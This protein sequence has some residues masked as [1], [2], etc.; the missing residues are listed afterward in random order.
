MVMPPSHNSCRAAILS[1]AETCGKETL[2][3]LHGFCAFVLFNASSL[4]FHPH[5]LTCVHV[6]CAFGLF[7][8]SGVQSRLVSSCHV[9]VPDYSQ[10]DG[11]SRSLLPASLFEHQSL[12][13]AIHPPTN[14]PHSVRKFRHLPH[15][16]QSP[17]DW[18]R[19][20]ID[21]SH[22]AGHCHVF[23]DARDYGH[24]ISSFRLFST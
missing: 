24:V 1:Y 12:G 3:S 14:R 17:S 21:P 5:S 13:Q 6:C 9:F 23:G 2:K 20:T 22:E 8:V 4:I 19:P 7:K 11:V 18:A 16:C 15:V 10:R